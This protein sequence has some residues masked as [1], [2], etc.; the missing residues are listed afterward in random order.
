MAR[1]PVANIYASAVALP[2]AAALAYLLGP[3]SIGEAATV[4]L[5]SRQLL[6]FVPSVATFLSLVYSLMFEF[7]QASHAASTDLLNWLPVTPSEYV[8]GSA[9]STSYFISP[10]VA[11]LVGV[12][13][14]L[15]LYIGDLG[16]WALGTMLAAAGVFLGISISEIVRAF[17]NRA[18]AGLHRRAGTMAM[19]LRF[20][21]GVAMIAVVAT[22]FNVN[23]FLRILGWFVGGVSL[24]WFVPL[25]WPSMAVIAAMAGSLTEAGIYTLLSLFFSLLLFGL[26]TITR[27]R[28]WAPVP[29]ATRL[30]PSKP[31]R[32][33]LPMLGLLGFDPAEAAIVRKDLRSLVRRREM[34]VWVAI[35][36][37]FFLM[38]IINSGVATEADGDVLSELGTLFSLGL[39]VLFL[40]FYTSLVG[41][42]QEGEAFLHLLVMPLG[43]E[44][45]A[46]AKI[47]ASMIPASL[48]L[49]AVLV[50]AVLAIRPGWEIM[51][52]LGI[53]ALPTL[54]E[55]S[56]IGMSLG[57][58]YPDFTEIPRARF[59]DRR[60]AYVGI[61]LTG[62][63]AS[64]TV[65]PSLALPYFLPGILG[66]AA[67]VGTGLAI[68]AGV[69]ILGYRA[70]LSGITSLRDGETV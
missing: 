59:I 57:S 10:V 21:F 41:F 66:L 35:P 42:G 17:M 34:A 24:I 4:E 39:G 28:C 44:Q 31:S 38:S 64:G 3:G 26:A 53:L 32:R 54:L 30:G 14:G 50:V 7:N 43:N 45:I 22:L 65:A 47:A 1:K 5:M 2:A 13:L 56:L 67:G 27:G 51:L 46:R 36:V 16:A 8:A 11:V 20:L 40:G 19:A 58:R 33:G 6:I 69:C 62:A 48:V 12:S 18:S 9:L 63:A 29:V 60:G 25:V 68:A 49:G 23:V 15:A 70:A 37:V 55:A 61:L 52:P